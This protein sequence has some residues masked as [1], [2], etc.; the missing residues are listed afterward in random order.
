MGQ[1]LSRAGLGQNALQGATP[2]ALI[3]G[4]CTTLIVALPLGLT[5]PSPSLPLTLAL[6]LGALAS[7]LALGRKQ[8]GVNGDFLGSAIVAGEIC[9]LIPLCLPI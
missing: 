1:S 4:G 6:A 3:L 9:A 2:F 7:L 8:D 5:L